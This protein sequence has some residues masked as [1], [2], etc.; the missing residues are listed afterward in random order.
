MHSGAF[1]YKINPYKCLDDA[2]LSYWQLGM[3]LAFFTV[4]PK[5]VSFYSQEGKK[6][7]CLRFFF[8]FFFLPSNQWWSLWESISTKAVSLSLGD[9][10]QPGIGAY[11]RWQTFSLW[12][13]DV[14]LQMGLIHAKAVDKWLCSGDW[15]SLRILIA[16]SPW[17]GQ[18]RLQWELNDH[19]GAIHSL[20]KASPGDSWESSA[21]LGQGP[22]LSQHILSQILQ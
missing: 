1:R 6:P 16:Y 11:N 3:L 18:H 22:G 17:L 10:A 5:V 8:F 14:F 12:G 9:K 20:E 7:Q 4:V 13:N 2:S 15:M 21:K 19:A